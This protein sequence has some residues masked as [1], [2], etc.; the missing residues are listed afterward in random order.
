MKYSKKAFSLIEVFIA[1]IVI[2]IAFSVFPSVITKSYN[3]LKFEQKQFIF[4][5][6][7]ALLKD[8]SVRVFDENNTGDNAI[9]V[10]QNEGDSELIVPRIGKIEINNN[11][12]R[13]GKSNLFLSNIGVDKDENLS[14]PSTL[15]DIDDFNGFVE[16]KI[17]GFPLK[18]EVFYISPVNNINYSNN[19]I[20]V[21]LRFDKKTSYHTNIKLLKIYN[22]K[23][24]TELYYP[25]YNIG[26]SKIFGLSEI[27][28]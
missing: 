6:E 18:L 12:Y 25:F 13:S 23:T 28:H 26:R 10:L 8:I 21:K 24:K 15:D 11:N 14:D 27:T 22:V 2:M 7:E 20:N 5:N 3:A 17:P 16:N 4:Y 9:Y 1:I 19:V